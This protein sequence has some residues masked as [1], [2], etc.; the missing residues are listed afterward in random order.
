MKALKSLP[1]KQIAINEYFLVGIAYSFFFSF[2][3]PFVIHSIHDHYED[4]R[5]V[6]VI[7]KQGLTMLCSP[8]LDQR[9]PV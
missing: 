7:F 9:R 3:F 8:G 4:Q 2:L 5:H 6:F 1:S